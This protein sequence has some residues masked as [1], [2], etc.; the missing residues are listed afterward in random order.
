[1]FVKAAETHARLR[2]LND[3]RDGSAFERAEAPILEREFCLHMRERSK[4]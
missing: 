3:S 2:L 1:M 4:L